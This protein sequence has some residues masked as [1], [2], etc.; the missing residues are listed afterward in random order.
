MKLTPRQPASS[1]KFLL[2]LLS[3]Y[4]GCLLITPRR[5]SELDGA[6][7]PAL[8]RGIGRDDGGEPWVQDVAPSTK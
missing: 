6:R 2:V 8:P 5:A 7:L 3:A 4:E 1:I